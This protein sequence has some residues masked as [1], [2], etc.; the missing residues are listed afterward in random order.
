MTRPTLRLVV[1]DDNLLV[2]EGVRRLLEE[3]SSFAV[4]ATVTSAPALLEAVDQERPDVAITDIRMP[5][6]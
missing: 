4:V 1:A 2:R 5:P 3:E 6:K